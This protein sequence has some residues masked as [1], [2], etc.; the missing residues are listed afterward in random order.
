MFKISLVADMR[1]VWRDNLFLLQLVPVDAAEE[2]VGLD[3]VEACLGMA[4]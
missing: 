4:A 2:W 1:F 3:V